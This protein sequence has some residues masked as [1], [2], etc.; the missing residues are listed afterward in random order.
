MLDDGHAGL[1]LDFGA[2]VDRAAEKGREIAVRRER[3]RW[4]EACRPA[5]NALRL[6]G[7]RR[8]DACE[9]YAREYCQSHYPSLL[10]SEARG[11][12]RQ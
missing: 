9:K 11:L 6:R 1:H 12:D 3:H 10:A 7:E 5:R 8:R 2:V 4:I